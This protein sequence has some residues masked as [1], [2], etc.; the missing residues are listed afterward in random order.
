MHAEFLMLNPRAV[1]TDCDARKTTESIMQTAS[2]VS[3]F[4]HGVRIK[5]LD[6]YRD[7][8]DSGNRMG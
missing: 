7:Q 1:N 3:A 6:C 4:H 2:A 8:R 5:L